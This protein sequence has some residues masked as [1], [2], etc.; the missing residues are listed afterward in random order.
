MTWG[1]RKPNSKT[2]KNNSGA[3]FRNTK[4]ATD[5]KPDYTGNA[6]I[7]GRIYRV[8]GWMNKSKTGTNYLRLIFTEPQAVIQDSV[9][10]VDPP[11]YVEPEDDL[12]F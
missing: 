7:E 10:P 11:E 4:E 8:A 9:K 6:T 3:L 2:M 5:K 1:R 12:P